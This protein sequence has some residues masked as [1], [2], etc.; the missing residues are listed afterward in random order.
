MKHSDKNSHHPKCRSTFTFG[1][2]K[3][4]QSFHHTYLQD[5]H[6][7]RSNHTIG[8]YIIIFDVAHT[9]TGSSSLVVYIIKALQ[10]FHFNN[11]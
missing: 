8:P 9:D 3:P 5:V 4:Y 2:I 11:D 10:I 1:F 6:N 7:I